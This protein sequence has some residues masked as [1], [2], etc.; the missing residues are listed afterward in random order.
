MKDK[1]ARQATLANRQAIEH[2]FESERAFIDKFAEIEA[3]LQNLSGRIAA[4]QALIGFLAKGVFEDQEEARDTIVLGLVASAQTNADILEKIE[5]GQSNLT[6]EF[7]D[8]SQ[9]VLKAIQQLV[10]DSA[11]YRKQ[12]T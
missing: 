5:Q 10:K 9:S 1:E 3:R 4:M 6:S 7:L 12:A 8:G 2:F 11:T